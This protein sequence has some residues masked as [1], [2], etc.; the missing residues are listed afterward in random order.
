MSVNV[1]ATSFAENGVPSDHDT[2]G[3]STKRS[4]VLSAVH[5]KLVASHGT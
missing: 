2:P 1:K 5:W 3:R 4:R